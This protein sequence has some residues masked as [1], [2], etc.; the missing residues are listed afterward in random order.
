MPVYFIAENE[1]ANFDH[2]RVKIG[3]SI[4]IDK[5]VSQLQTGSPYELKL[6]GWIECENDKSLEDKLH[7]KY[8]KKHAHRE[9]FNLSASDVLEELRQH[10]T[11]AYIAVNDNAFEV[12]SLDQD[13]LPEYV[14]AWQWT[15]IEHEEFCP[16]C[17][18]GGGL[19]YN[20]NYGGDRCLKCG[21]IG[22]L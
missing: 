10:L 20:E 5:R 11:H 3:V 19:S 1:N 12:V 9:W 13:G 14:G 6:M 22:D 4:Q 18:W 17:G 8:K 15:D 7:T 21:I 16:Q 2:L